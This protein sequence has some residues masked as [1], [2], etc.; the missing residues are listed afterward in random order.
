MIS[1]NI[2]ETEFNK[3]ELIIWVIYGN[4]NGMYRF[5]VRILMPSGPTALLLIPVIILRISISDTG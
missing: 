3:Q 4:R 1:S 2:E 5:K